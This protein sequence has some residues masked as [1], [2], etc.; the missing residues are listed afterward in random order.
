MSPEEIISL[1]DSPT[2]KDKELIKKAYNFSEKAHAGQTR[3]SGEPYFNHLF[4]TVKIL[5]ELKMDASSH[6]CRLFA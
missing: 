3:K 2:D 5:A 1:L 6:R 4:Q